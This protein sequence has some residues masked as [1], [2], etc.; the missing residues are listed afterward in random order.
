MPAS[1]I[2]ARKIAIESKGLGD[3]I[4]VGN[5]REA[6]GE[7]LTGKIVIQ[8]NELNGP[9]GVGKNFLDVPQVNRGVRENR[10]ER[11]GQNCRKRQRERADSQVH[12]P[13][14]SSRR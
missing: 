11:N 1:R 12:L 10:W 14:A 2:G 4:A 3:A 13:R 8:L 9:L 6:I 5:Q 7:V